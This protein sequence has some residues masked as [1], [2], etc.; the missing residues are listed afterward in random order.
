MKFHDML[1]FSQ[2]TTRL[3]VPQ[4]QSIIVFYITYCFKFIIFVKM[5]EFSI[6]FLTFF[7]RC[8]YMEIR[9]FQRNERDL[10]Q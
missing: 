1:T 6:K 4:T 5:H 7:D 2:I 9:S 10:P 3:S 8:D